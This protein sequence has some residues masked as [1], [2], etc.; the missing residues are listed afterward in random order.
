MSEEEL[1]QVKSN[2][3]VLFSLMYNFE[4]RLKD[5]MQE[6]IDYLEKF[7]DNLLD[8]YNKIKAEN[9]NYKYAIIPRLE[10][11][12]KGLKCGIKSNLEEELEEVKAENQFLKYQVNSAFGRGFIHRDKIRA[13]IKEVKQ[14]E[15]VSIPDI[16]ESQKDFCIDVLKELLEE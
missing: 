5:E 8:L 2:I 4:D 13:K 11:E 3:R 10:G 7:I 15:N 12:I 6:R 14:L 1:R 16:L 9:K